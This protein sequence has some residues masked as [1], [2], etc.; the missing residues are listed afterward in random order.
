MDRSSA[1]N[2]Q[3]KNRQ[4]TGKQTH[5]DTGSVRHVEAAGQRCEPLIAKILVGLPFSVALPLQVDD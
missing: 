4:E 2:C 3:S 5:D 1:E